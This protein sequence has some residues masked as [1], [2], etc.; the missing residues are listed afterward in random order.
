MS[1]DPIKGDKLAARY[2]GPYTVVRK[3]TGG[4]YVLK[5]GTGEELGRRF[6]PSQLKLVLDDFEETNIY[7]V[8]KILDHREQPGEGVEY[9]VK[10]KGFE[11]TKDRTWEPPENFIERKCIVDYW[12]SRNLPEAQSLQK[13]PNES[14]TAVTKRRATDEQQEYHSDQRENDSVVLNNI[15]DEVQSKAPQR[16]RGRPRNNAARAEVSDQEEQT[17]EA[18]NELQRPSVQPGNNAALIAGTDQNESKLK[19]DGKNAKSRKERSTHASR[20]R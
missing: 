20:R 12:K 18:Q 15:T 8:E 17:V 7:E 4:S 11:K 14:R 9:L 19:L 3:N 16:K 6:A 2:E 10:W 1:L 5:D 13:P